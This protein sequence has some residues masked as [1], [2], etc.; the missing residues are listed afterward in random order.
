MMI[1]DRYVLK[2]FFKVAIVCALSMIGLFV[3]IDL[4]EHLEE[5]VELGKTRGGLLS[6][7]AEY[8][9]PRALTF[10]DRTSGLLAL[11]AAI[12]VLTLMKRHRELE[13]ILAGGV[14]LK[15]IVRPLFIGVIAVA[16]LAIIN[17]EVLIPHHKDQLVRDVSNWLGQKQ[18][19]IRPHY[20]YDTGVFIAGK[21]GIA[22]RQMILAPIFQLPAEID[23]Y[24]GKILAEQ[25]IYQRANGDHPGGYLVS[26]VSVPARIAEIDSATVAGRT[27]IMSPRQH[28]WLADD[29]CFIASNLDFAKMTETESVKHYSSTFE[30]IKSLHNPSLDYG[31]QTRVSVHAR[32]VQPFLDLSLLFVG[33]PIVITR[34]DRNIFMAI[35]IAFSLLAGFFLLSMTSH[36]L[37]DYGLITPACAAWIPLM[38]L[39][40]FAW[41]LSRNL[42]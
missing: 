38:V 10:F 27:I 8:Y 17:R 6:V 3:I 20:D 1:I 29:Q 11:T 37:G 36:G 15:R 26:N 30:L 7:V 12:F 33:I 18:I 19:N 31:S 23:G 32:F 24:G 39:A 16:V 13:A 35:G 28:D 25:A 2:L 40:P 21:S 4:F 22:A 14:P 5:F 41:A 42:K 9:G 34:N